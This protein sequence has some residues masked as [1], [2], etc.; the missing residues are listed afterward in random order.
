MGP[1]ILD[2][3]HELIMPNP[4]RDDRMRLLKRLGLIV[5]ISIVG[6]AIFG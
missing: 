6:V 3:L 1:F 5:V 2:W 4:E